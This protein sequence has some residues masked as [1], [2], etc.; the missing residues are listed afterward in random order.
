MATRRLL[1]LLLLAAAALV[2]VVRATPTPTAW[3]VTSAP[4]PSHSPTASAPAATTKAPAATT[5]APAA[6]TQAPPPAATTTAPAATTAKPTAAAV[7]WPVASS[8]SPAPE[9]AMLT[10]SSLSRE[11]NGTCDPDYELQN[12]TTGACDCRPGFSGWGCRMCAASSACA[13]VRGDLTCAQGLK[14]DNRTEFKTYQ[15]TLDPDLQSIFDDGALSV[16]CNRTSQVCTAAVYKAARGVRSEHV[17]DCTLTGC[18]FANGS[19]SGACAQIDCKCSDQCSPLAKAVI[20]QSLSGKPAKIRATN[21]TSLSIDIEGSPM[22]LSAQ[23]NASQ[24]E[25]DGSGGGGS[26]SGSGS[27][28]GDDEPTWPSGLVIAIVT[29]AG[30]AALI[31]LCVFACSCFV[32]TRIRRGQ[33]DVETELSSLTP[34]SGKLLEFKNI[35]CYATKAEAAKDSSKPGS[36]SSSSDGGDKKRILHKISAKVARG[37]VLGILGPSGSGKTSLLNALAAVENGRSVTSGRILV[38]G[39]KIAKDYRR[40]AAYVQQDDSLYSTLTVRECIQYSAQ[41][42]LPSTASESAK[43]AMVERVISELNL[44]H[45]VNSRIGSHG[46]S[47]G[48]SGGERR[49]VSIGMELVTSPQILFLDEPTSG[50]D[51]SSANSV[52]QLVKELA[53]HGRIVVLSIHQPSAKS[54]L[55]LDQVMLLAK[56]KMLY[57]GPPA[58]SKDYFQDLGFLCPEV[59]G[60]ECCL[61]VS[62]LGCSSALA[63]VP[64]ITFASFRLGHTSTHELVL[65]MCDRTRTSRTSSWTSRPTRRTSRTSERT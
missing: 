65:C 41:L 16:A 18:V 48:I 58:E 57:H 55:L 10:V 60:Y 34:Q 1:L 53:G 19:A 61:C 45:V 28:G 5:K 14:Y 64:S 36:S 31:L 6:T 30:A 25:P 24:C 56:G 22:P 44:G 46:P 39:K 40:V 52:V 33:T 15:C 23:C 62:V 12:A 27:S 11:G 59:R 26:G 8:P 51:S 20:E 42:R 4:L 21:G 35:S 3:S 49:R 50:L 13:A 37:S 29:C 9:A 54:F 32:S 7:A 43:D 63:S 38:D 2:A 47:R 17:L